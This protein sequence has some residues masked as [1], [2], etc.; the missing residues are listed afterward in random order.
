MAKQ[1]KRHMDL[2]VQGDLVTTNSLSFRNVLINGG[3][4]IWQRGT[5]GTSGYIAD[6]WSTTNTSAIS[7]STDVPNSDFASSISMSSTGAFPLLIQRVESL[8]SRPLVSQ[9]VTVSFWA[10]STA[11]THS[12]FV[13]MYRANTTDTFGTYPYG[14]ATIIGAAVIVAASPSSTWTK[15]SAN[16]DIPATGVN[17][18]QVIIGRGNVAAASTTLITGVQLEVGSSATPF[19]RRPVGLELQLCQ[20]YYHRH[21]TSSSGYYGFGGVETGTA[22]NIAY[23]LPQNMRT[24]PAIDGVVNPNGIAAE[25]GTGSFPSGFTNISCGLASSNRVVRVQFS[26]GTGGTVGS[27]G[28][29][30]GTATNYA[31]F[32]FTA[33]L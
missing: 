6:R 10:K 21:S 32:G 18:V 11:G 19:E 17:G 27:M 1:A 31:D 28:M 33:E 15:Y 22:I 8:N 30:R 5:S 20:R 26:G 14:S 29:F 13:E 24:S 2:N 4:D 9:Q 25:F 16:F 23:T 7:K 12:L 3:F